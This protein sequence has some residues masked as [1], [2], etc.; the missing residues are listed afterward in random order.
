MVEGLLLQVCLPQVQSLYHFLLD[1]AS[2]QQAKTCTSPLQDE[3]TDA[4]KHMQ[5]ISQGTNT[6]LNQVK[7]RRGSELAPVGGMTKKKAQRRSASTSSS[8]RSDF[9]QSEDSD[10]EMAVC[11]A[12]NCQLPEGDEVDWV[13]CD[14]SCNQWFHQ[15]CV[16]VTAEMAEKEDYVCVTCTLK[17]GHMRK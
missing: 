13:Q 6:S 8:P 5:F 14:G 1:R 3:P 2:S 7:R 10:G 9:S 12:E 15:V 4:D 17:D 11:P 16:G